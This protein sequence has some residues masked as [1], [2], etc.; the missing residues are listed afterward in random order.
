MYE[1]LT[2]KIDRYTVVWLNMEMKTSKFLQ[3]VTTGIKALWPLSQR[4]T[5]L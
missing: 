3:R 1:R 2:T 5:K 4:E